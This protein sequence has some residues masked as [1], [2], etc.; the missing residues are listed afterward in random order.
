[1]SKMPQIKCKN[2]GK[3]FT[4]KSEKNIF[5]SRKCFKQDYYYREKERND[6]TGFPMYRCPDCG[7]VIEME[8]HPIRNNFEWLEWR[9]VPCPGCNTL[10]IFVSD[11]L[12]TED[13]ANA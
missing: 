7:Q 9:K 10:M 1:M 3:P 4:P 5:C 13:E 6:D 12:I 11:E 8:V 2:C